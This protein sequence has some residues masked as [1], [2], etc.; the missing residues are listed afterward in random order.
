[1]RSALA[2]ADRA[3]TIDVLSNDHDPDGTLDANSVAIASPPASGSAVV[4]GDGTI[5]YTPGAALDN[6]TFGYTVARAL[7]PAVPRL[8]LAAS[9]GAL[10]PDVDAL[11]MPAGWDIYLR[12]HDIGTHSLVGSV[13]VAFAVAAAW[14]LV[15]AFGLAGAG[16]AA[17]LASLTSLGVQVLLVTTIRWRARPAAP[18]PGCPVEALG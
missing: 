13:P 2:R 3:I 8:A 11:F 9:L 16:A 6:V 15:P 5:T 7:R 10:A 12:A 4:N 18:R 14:W 1:M 17:L